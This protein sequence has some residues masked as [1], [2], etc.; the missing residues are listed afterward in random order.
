MGSTSQAQSNHLENNGPALG[1]WIADNGFPKE[2]ILNAQYDL[3]FYIINQDPTLALLGSVSIY[4]S[5]DGGS[6]NPIVSDVIAD[7]PLLPGDSMLVKV[8]EFKFGP[9]VFSTTGGITYDIIVW[10]MTIGGPP[11]GTFLIP[12][13]HVISSIANMPG[14]MKEYFF[15]DDWVSVFPNPSSGNFQLLAKLPES[16]QIDLKVYNPAGMLVI[17]QT[18]PADPGELRLA[19]S[20]EDQP[21]GLYLYRLRQKSRIFSGH[22]LK[23]K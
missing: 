8:E 5:I 16:M 1:I 13:V 21:D 15:R 7:S 23:I 12:E 19:V 22:I 17:D 11:S 14:D 18:I 2:I 6:P 20:L 10:P 3:E 4:M 9:S